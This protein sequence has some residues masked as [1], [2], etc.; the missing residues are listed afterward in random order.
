MPVASLANRPF[1]VFDFPAL[2]RSELSAE[3]LSPFWNYGQKWIN[4][5][6]CQWSSES[7][8]SR[9]S[10]CVSVCPENNV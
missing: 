4:Y 2:W 3:S 6:R 5:R 8:R 1:L 9:V 7:S 10:V